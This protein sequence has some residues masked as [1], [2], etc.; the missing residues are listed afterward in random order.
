MGLWYYD[1]PSLC[2]KLL[3][4]VSQTVF[5]SL[6]LI[7]V[8]LNDY[9]APGVQSSLHHESCQSLPSSSAAKTKQL[10]QDTSDL[11]A[12]RRGLTVTSPTQKQN[13]SDK[14]SSVP[15]H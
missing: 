10:F 4:S 8:C 9:E 15:Q 7:V 13:E 1:N 14:L 11:P 5:Q 6:T 12:M 2:T 3:T